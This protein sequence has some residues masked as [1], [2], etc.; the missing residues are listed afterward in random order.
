[1]AALD[2]LVLGSAIETFKGGFD[3]AAETTSRTTRTSR[4]RCAPPAT[5]T[6]TTSASSSGSPRSW[7]GSAHANADAVRRP[8]RERVAPSG[9]HA[10]AH[11][12][13][14]ARRPEREAVAVAELALGVRAHR[15]ERPPAAAL[16]RLQLDDLAV[17]GT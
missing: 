9:A 5:T 7:P 1:M 13:R 6:S 15:P 10:R 2:F 3:R 17:A 11:R 8:E 4:A 14:R 16:E 12:E